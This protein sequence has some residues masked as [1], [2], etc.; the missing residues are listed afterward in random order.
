MPRPEEHDRRKAKWAKA[1]AAL[2]A[3]LD[4]WGQKRRK[5]I[6]TAEMVEAKRFRTPPG[7]REYARLGDDLAD[8][9]RK[10]NT[11]ERK[12]RELERKIKAH[13]KIKPR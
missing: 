4:A 8:L 2:R 9:G 6:S 10:W 11:V 1:D 5:L 12:E 3:E 7:T 13:A